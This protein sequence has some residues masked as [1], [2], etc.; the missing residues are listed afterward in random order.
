MDQGS[1]RD[2]Q[3]LALPTA[4]ALVYFGLTGMTLDATNVQRTQ[5]TLNDI[6]QAISVLVPVYATFNGKPVKIHPNVLKSARFIAG[7][8]RL[9]TQDGTEFSGL[10]VQRRDITAA[11]VT[12]KAARV[13]F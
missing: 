13:R 9:V 2:L 1:P 3:H 4:A 11:V 8:H 12:L 5:N 10:T 7:A 6:A